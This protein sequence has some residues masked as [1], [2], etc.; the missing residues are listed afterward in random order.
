MYGGEQ[1]GTSVSVSRSSIPRISTYFILSGI[2]ASRK[3]QLTQTLIGTFYSHSKE[4]E[5]DQFQ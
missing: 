3:T 2:K 5:Q 4:T 1:R